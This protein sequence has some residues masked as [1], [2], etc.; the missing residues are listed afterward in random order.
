MKDCDTLDLTKKISDFIPGWNEENNITVAELQE[1]ASITDAQMKELIEDKNIKTNIGNFVKNVYDTSCD[2]EEEHN[3]ADPIYPFEKTM[4]YEINSYGGYNKRIY[5]NPPLKNITT[6]KFLSE[7]IKKCIDRRIPFDMKGFGSLKHGETSLDG[8]ILYSSNKYFDSHLECLEE[9]IKENPDL[10]NTFGTPIYTGAMV[11]DKNN[12]TYY[13][14]GA[15]LPCQIRP[16]YN[17]SLPSTYNDY[18]DRAINLTYL[19]SSAKLIKQYFVRV[20]HQYK[21]LDEDTKLLINKLSNPENCSA[22]ELINIGNLNQMEEIR[23]MSYYIISQKKEHGTKQEQQDVMDRLRTTFSNNFKMVCSVL[24]FKDKDHIQTSIYQDESF[25]NFEKTIRALE[26][27]G[28]G[29]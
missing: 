4:Y 13:T 15:G 16:P 17:I 2:L 24:K 20:L 9:V 14:I 7:Y 3:G 21:E 11:K 28:D 8:T 23:K 19:I 5:L 25:I 26:E 22:E 29:R 12:R 18:I 27:G 10:M 1:I 6:Y